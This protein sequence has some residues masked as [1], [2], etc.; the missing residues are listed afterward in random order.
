MVANAVSLQ[1]GVEE[2]T[3]KEDASFRGSFSGHER[4]RFYLN[5]E[6]SSGFV[7]LG[8]SLGL[9]FSDDGRSF[10]PVDI[11]GDGDLDIPFMS[12]QSLRLLENRTEGGLRHYSRIRLQATKSQHHALG[13]EVILHCAETTQRD[14][15]KVAAGFQTQVPMDLHFGLGKDCSEKIDWIEVRWPSKQVERFAGLPVDRLL[16]IKEGT[17]PEI[18]SINKW[19]ATQKRSRP[20]EYDSTQAVARL[21]GEKSPLSEN[22]KPALINFW[23]PWCKPCQKELP[24]LKT[25]SQGFQGRVQF[26]GVSVE[27]DDL[28]S[29][30]KT[31]QAMG[32]DYPQFIADDPVMESFF[33]SDGEAPLPATF[34]FRADGT[35]HR[36]FFRSVEENELD[37]MLALISDEK[38]NVHHL[39]LLAEIR[40]GQRKYE[41]ARAI[42]E[43]IL[44]TAPDQTDILVQY[45]SVLSFLGRH[46]QSIDILQRATRLSSKDPYIWYRLGWTEKSMGDLAGAQKSYAVA[47]SLKNDSY[48]Y[49]NALGAALTAL[50]EH[51]QSNQVYEDLIK[52]HP[53]HVDAWV[54]LGKTRAVLGMAS[55]EEAFLRALSLDVDHKEAR[56]LLS[57]WRK[58]AP[59]KP[60]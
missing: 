30:R 28:D 33:G 53:N 39:Q 37:A 36:M 32:I 44:S 48:Q 8:Y 6:K 23:A 20:S 60:R 26:A 45:G 51:A 17:A 25:L 29:V 15:V 38:E 34:V 27:K 49:G 47:F 24:V 31:I 13:A 7:E 12:L 10:A 19:G 2:E 59:R 55:A 21:N 52:A 35:L 43:R 9:D 11:D 40:M 41:E 54:N 14:Y 1:K 3:Y 42:F 22:G 56:H 5:P 46:R 16:F 57:L 58:T 50:G 18:R 4:D